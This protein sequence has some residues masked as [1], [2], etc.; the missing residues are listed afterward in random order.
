MNKIINKFLRILYRK[1]NRK[2]I[3]LQFQNMM[4]YKPN[5]DNPKTFNEKINWIKLNYY[6]ELYEKCADKIEVR[7]YV[8]EKGLSNILT[9]LYGKYGSIDEIDFEKLPNKFVLKTT[10]SCG[11]VVVVNDK[12]TIDKNE[13]YRILNKSLKTNLYN[14]GREWQYKNLKPRILAE[15]LIATNNKEL[16]DYKFFCFNGKVE[17]VYIAYGSE[18]NKN[19]CIDFYDKNWNYINVKKKGHKNYGPIEKPKKLDEMIKISEILSNDFEHVRVDLYCE[20]NKIYFGELTF[21]TGSGYSAFI[22]NEFDYELGSKID[23]NN[24]K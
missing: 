1:N 15:E 13:V 5:L 14:I 7:N 21:T 11:G 4:G 8:T 24:L 2:Y 3:E 10:H 22:P 19:Y 16:T 18:S 6:N 12:N 17:Y 9:K 20:N 23:I